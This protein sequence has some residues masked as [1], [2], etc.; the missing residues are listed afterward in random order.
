MFLYFLTSTR[1]SKLCVCFSKIIIPQIVNAFSACT[2]FSDLFQLLET[3]AFR[4]SD[5]LYKNIIAN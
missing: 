4:G 1:T 2:I 5:E 3:F